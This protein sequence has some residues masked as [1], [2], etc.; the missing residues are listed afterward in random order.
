ML[1]VNQSKLVKKIIFSFKKSKIH[2]KKD[3]M[4]EALTTY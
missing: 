4:F 2:D 3:H 1:T